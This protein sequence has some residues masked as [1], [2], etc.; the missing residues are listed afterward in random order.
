MTDEGFVLA[1]WMV[2]FGAIIWM[3]GFRFMNRR[4]LLASWCAG[5]LGGLFLLFF[6]LLGMRSFSVSDM[7]ESA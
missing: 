4:K 7:A 2:I 6:A 3:C 1:Q 5:V